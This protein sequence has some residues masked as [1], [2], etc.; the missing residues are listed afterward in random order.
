[1]LCQRVWL[2]SKVKLADHYEWLEMLFVI[3]RVVLLR[4]KKCSYLYSALAM[5]M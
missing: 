1:M 2:D 3:L 5:L 4:T